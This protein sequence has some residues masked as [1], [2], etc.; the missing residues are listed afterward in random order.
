MQGGVTHPPDGYPGP[1]ERTLGTPQRVPERANPP[2]A[3]R[4]AVFSSLS[5]GRRRLIEHLREK[6]VVPIPIRRTKHYLSLRFLT[7]SL[8]PV[9]GDAPPSHRQ[10]HSDLPTP[11]ILPMQDLPEREQGPAGDWNG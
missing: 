5:A 1:S 4:W 11:S 2:E 9:G 8:Y 3:D 7:R 10:A 6:S